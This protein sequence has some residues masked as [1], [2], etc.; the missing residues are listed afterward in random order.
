[1]K[2]A[3]RLFSFLFVFVCVLSIAGCQA[4]DETQSYM[5]T[6]DNFT[7]VCSYDVAENKTT[8]ELNSYIQNDTIY[9]IEK[10][11][12]VANLYLDDTLVWKEGGVTFDFDVRYGEKK[13]FTFNAYYGGGEVNR[14]EYVSW[15]ATYKTLWDSYAPWFIISIIVALVVLLIFILVMLI[16]DLDLEDVVDFFEDHF[17]LLPV[18]FIIFIPYLID[19]IS[20]GSWSWVPLLILGGAV[21][22][23]VVLGLIA[24]GLKDIFDFGLL[25]FG[26]RERNRNVSDEPKVA[27]EKGNEYTIDDL[28]NDKESLMAFS[29][30]DLIDWC[31]ENG[32]TG[33]SK[34]NK[35]ELA[36]FIVDNSDG[37]T[38]AKETSHVKHKNDNKKSK[39]K[40]GITFD[41][42]AGLDDA[43]K[44]FIEKAIMPIMHKELYEKFGKKVGGGILLYGLPGTGKTMFAEA[45]SNELDALFIPVKCSDIKSKWYGES[46]QKVKEIFTKARKAETAIIFFDEF[47]AIGAKR[48][49]NSENGNNDLVPQILSEMQG[50]GSSSS[51]SVILVIAATNKPWSIDS[52]FLRPGRFDEKIYIPLP[53]FEARK[54]LFE[55]QISK[56]PHEEDLD[57][58]LLAKLTEGCNGAD[59]KEVCEKLK[60]SAIIDTI[61]KGEEQ[62]IGM[63][64]VER[65][66]DSIKSSVQAAEIHQ[67][68]QFR[69]S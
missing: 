54:K 18:A 27:D 62:T 50:V 53:D 15:T 14:I 38:E 10:V 45:A 4:T 65:I 20:S 1:M 7:Y 24:L 13:D 42:I 23:V 58:D 16:N 28:K 57:Y 40:K 25:C 52:A 61:E 22:S 21:L 48:T 46:E 51:D 12:I 29:K 56:L 55:L 69:N 2:K 6:G 67:L 5:G 44:V 39:D 37:E 63:D 9:T 11:T 8:I 66:K 30:E 49:D 26:G 47:E 3:V 41:D 32:L 31:R 59:I 17:F 19:G 43:K 33:Y 64:D 34:L 36:A 35:S 60:M 68:E